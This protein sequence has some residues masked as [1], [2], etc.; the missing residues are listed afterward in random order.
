[1]ISPT[2]ENALCLDKVPVKIVEISLRVPQFLA[3]IFV[4]E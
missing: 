3:G 1:M 2:Y 4:R